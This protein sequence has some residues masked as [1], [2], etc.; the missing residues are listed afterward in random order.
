MRHVDAFKNK[1]HRTPAVTDEG[2]G[3]GMRGGRRGGESYKVPWV[4][5]PCGVPCHPLAGG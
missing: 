5:M 3:G 1:S 4:V 2:E